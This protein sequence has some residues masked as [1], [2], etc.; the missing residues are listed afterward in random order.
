MVAEVM[1]VIRAISYTKSHLDYLISHTVVD[2]IL[3]V[4]WIQC[5]L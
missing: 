5:I 1:P 4:D 2:W 3:V